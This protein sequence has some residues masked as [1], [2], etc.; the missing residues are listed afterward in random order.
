MAGRQFRDCSAFAQ[1]DRIAGNQ[2]RTDV[3]VHHHRERGVEVS[4][5][6][7]AHSNGLPSKRAGCFLCVSLVGCG[8]GIVGVDEKCNQPSVWN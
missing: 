3:L 7:R 1:Q 2:S 8:G 4:F 6:S 5:V